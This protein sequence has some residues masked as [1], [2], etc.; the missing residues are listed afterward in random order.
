MS[1]VLAP[2]NSVSIVWAMPTTFWRSDTSV[3][4][5]DRVWML[6]KKFS[7]WVLSPV[8]PSSVKAEEMAC[9]PLDRV[10]APPWAERDWVSC[11]FR[12]WF[13]R[14]CTLSTVEP[15]PNWRLPNSAV[16][17]VVITADCW[18]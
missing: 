18:L 9:S 4:L 1:V 2:W 14:A 8:V 15:V 3:G 10:S 5:P 17:L 12:Y 16:G 7:I 6:E 11:R 13:R